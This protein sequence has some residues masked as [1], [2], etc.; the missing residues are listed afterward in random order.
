MQSK[1]S[2]FNTALF[3]K[4]LTRFW[5]LWGGV[6]LLMCLAPLYVL[7][8]IF[9][10]PGLRMDSG[11]VREVLYM[12]LLVIVPAFSFGYAILTAMAVWGY[13]FNARSVGLMHALPISR[14]SLFITN[15][16]SGLAMM[17]IPY[18]VT[19]FLFGLIALCNG[20]M[21]LI[22]FFTTIAGVALMTVLF[23]SMATLCAMLTGHMAAMP[24][25]YLIGN[26]L[27]VALDWLFGLLQS[28]F[29]VGVT[30]PYSGNL[31]FLS[32]LVQIYTGCSGSRDD[33][34]Y[35][36]TGFWII[37]VYGLVGLALMALAWLLYRLRDSERAGDVVAFKW[38]RPVFRY[39]ISFM[40]AISLGHLL[41]LFFNSS[42]GTYYG[43]TPARV[44]PMILCMI[45]TGLIGFYI[46]SML[47]SK[48]PRVFKGSW[49][50]AL[51][52]CAGAAVVC[53][54]V[55][56]DVF[57]V[58]SRVPSMGEIKYVSFN[59]SGAFPEL[60][61]TPE[62]NPELVKEVLALHQAIVDDSDYI[63]DSSP[64][65]WQD[66][67]ATETV[68]M[69]YRLA[70]GRALHRRYTLCI[71]KERA[72]EEG[73][74]DNVL[75]SF[76]RSADYQLGIIQPAAGYELNTITFYGYSNHDNLTIGGENAEILYDALA[77]DAKA[78]NLWTGWF[79]SE[80][81]SI[82]TGESYIAE[83]GL[84]FRSIPATEA[85]GIN[86]GAYT[87]SNVYVRPSMEH[88]L[89]ALAEMGYIS[90]E[91]IGQ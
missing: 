66:G 51:I 13:L 60:N 12:V 8:Y 58:E 72:E 84:E 2:L 38:L 77:R 6:T 39:G 53:L 52:V 19:G 88:T 20:A 23:F 75:A 74:S 26:F 83:L 47:L 81:G 64:N 78:G 59:K 40:F 79:D 42:T 11:D 45:F 57:G 36:L 62:E 30:N 65:R 18:A 21:D 90:P 31:N 49:K 87:Y 85:Y 29:L 80:D 56:T 67:Y 48:T 1:N 73:T 68:R 76:L 5:P 3:K 63:R 82:I 70:N 69:Y 28:E 4:N 24:V 9:Q 15:S 46:A 71:S 86:S 17:L 35:N 89:A 50:G 22:A 10:N 41:Y 14:M 43:E 91:E 33:N 54:A 44:V 34:S 37:V 61:V 55:S 32:P 27:A 25:F 16:L 7:L